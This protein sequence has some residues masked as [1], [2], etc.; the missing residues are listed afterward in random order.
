VENLRHRLSVDEFRR[1]ADAYHTRAF[2]PWLSRT[3]N[4]FLTAAGAVLTNRSS[5]AGHDAEHG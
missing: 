4:T 2:G 5:A 1:L 3:P